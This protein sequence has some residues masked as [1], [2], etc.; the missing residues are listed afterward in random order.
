LTAERIAGAKLLVAKIALLAEADQQHAI[1]ERAAHIVEEKR[2]AKLALHVP[3][4]DDF[5]D[6]T[7]RCAVDQFRRERKLAIV[8]NP[9]DDARAPLL[10]GASAFYGK[11]HRCP[12]L[13]LLGFVTV[14]R[15]RT[16]YRQNRL[17]KSKFC[18]R[19]DFSAQSRP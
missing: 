18:T 2:R 9:D 12:S 4:T 6:I 19:H 5:A 8:E 7:V 13:S 17:K 10:L 15:N 1:G 14:R 11:F 16:H 3:A